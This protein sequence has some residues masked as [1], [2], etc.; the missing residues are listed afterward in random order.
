MK[1]KSTIKRMFRIVAATIVLL[2]GL[3]IV[4]I[5]LVVEPDRIENNTQQ[6]SRIDFKQAPS[7]SNRAEI[8]QLLQTQ[9]GV[10]DSYFSAAGDMLIVRFDATQNK[11]ANLLQVLQHHFDVA[12]S[13]HTVSANDAAKGCP[14]AGT[15]SV[16]HK[17]G[18]V[19]A[20]LF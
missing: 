13:L 10:K 2:L 7:G 18:T 11:S 9:P 17:L 12:A 20:G 6:L 19:V 3:L 14:V 15:G 16:I 1:R 4:H 5:A 8:M